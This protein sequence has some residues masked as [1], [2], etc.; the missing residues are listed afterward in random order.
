MKTY[1]VYVLVKRNPCSICSGTDEVRLIWQYFIRMDGA[2]DFY[3]CLQW[4]K[5]LLSNMAREH[6][7]YDIKWNLHFGVILNLVW[8]KRNCYVFQSETWS[9]QDVIQ[10][11]GRLARDYMQGISLMKPLNDTRILSDANKQI[12]WKCPRFVM[13]LSWKV[14]A[15]GL[16]AVWCVTT[17]EL[18]SVE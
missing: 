4:R 1:V 13:V 9:A 2:G 18:F 5:W 3:T 7:V 15:K 8:W 14:E 16:V 17:Q 11:A 6:V 10:K 12:S